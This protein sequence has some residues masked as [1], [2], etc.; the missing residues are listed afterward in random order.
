MCVHVFMHNVSEC[1]CV[2]ACMHAYVSECVCILVTA[3]TQWV[4]RHGI[5]ESYLSIPL[6]VLYSI[7][8]CK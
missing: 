5:L 4:C 1:V 2:C 8:L 3:F 7:I 6:Y